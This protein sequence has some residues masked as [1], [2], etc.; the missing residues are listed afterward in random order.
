MSATALAVVEVVIREGRGS[1]LA[2]E[3]GVAAK[4]Q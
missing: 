2:A 1:K 4:D 3:E